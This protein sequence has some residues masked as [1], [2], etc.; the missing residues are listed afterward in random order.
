MDKLHHRVAQV[1]VVDAYAEL[2]R[3]VSSL[4]GADFL[5][6]S[7]CAGWAVGDVLYHVLL[8]AQRAL[9]TFA[10]PAKRAP[11]I[12]HVSYWRNWQTN[13][14]DLA[15][16][17]HGR[18][19]RIAAAAYPEP[20][21]LAH[22]WLDTARAVA[23]V[24]SGIPGSDVVATQSHALT[25]T[26]FLSTL[27]VEATVHHLDMLLELPG[28]PGPR[29]GAIELTV[30]VLDALLGPVKERPAWDDMTWIL[31]A[32]GRLPLTPAEERGLGPPVSRFPLIG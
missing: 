21:A 32:T 11:T 13:R 2:S 20:G 15:A 12:D 4:G 10:T 14:N 31:K 26:D 24:A 23:H 9:V 17:A 7:R 22:Q 28:A 25:V 1:A 5:R 27:A 8:D 3:L 19:V 30:D 6:P 29:P 18:F 16:A